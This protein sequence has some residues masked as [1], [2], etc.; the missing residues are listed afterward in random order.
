MGILCGYS[1]SLPLPLSVRVFARARARAPVRGGRFYFTRIIIPLEDRGA[2]SSFSRRAEP[3]RE[4]S[5]AREPRL[6]MDGFSFNFRQALVRFFPSLSLI[7]F[8]GPY[9]PAFLRTA[10]G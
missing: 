2:D 7:P 6:F 8:V 10:R 9:R 5:L 3:R 1:L 4:A